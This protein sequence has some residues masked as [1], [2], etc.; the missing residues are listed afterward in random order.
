M[1][2]WAYIGSLILL[3]AGCNDQDEQFTTLQNDQDEKTQQIEQIVKEY[4]EV[5]HSYIVAIEDHIL[6]AMQVKPWQRW[7][8]QSIE[9]KVKKHMKEQFPSEEVTI[10]TDFKLHWEAEKLLEE[11]DRQ[12]QLKRLEQL[13][14]LAKEEA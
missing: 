9:E 4:S 6:V 14:D 10:S 13:A 1:K 12:K 11:K 5:E 8:K 2:K 3:L 7:N